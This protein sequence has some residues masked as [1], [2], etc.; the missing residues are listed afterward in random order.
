MNDWAE[1]AAAK[2]FEQDEQRQENIQRSN[3]EAK[4]KD[5]VGPRLFKEL[6]EW[7][8]SQVEKYNK[9]RGKEELKVQRIEAAKMASGIIHDRIVVSRLDGKKL[10]LKIEYLPET[11]MITYEC[12][13]GKG[14]FA[15]QAGDD[16]QMRFETPYHQAVSVEDIGT[17]ALS[18]FMSSQF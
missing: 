13:A 2:A 9:L 10:A 16:G 11:G 5:E 4:I 17:E 8:A 3:R 1:E 6:I 18:K 15:L 12:G 7:I 14:S